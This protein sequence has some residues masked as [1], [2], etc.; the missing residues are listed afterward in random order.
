MKKQLAESQRATQL[1]TNLLV[2]GQK[3]ETKAEVEARI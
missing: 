3:L 2:S 1:A